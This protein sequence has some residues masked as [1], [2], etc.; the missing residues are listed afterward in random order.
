MCRWTLTCQTKQYVQVN[1][2][3]SQYL[4]CSVGVPQGSIWDPVLF[5]MYIDLPNVC[6][7]VGTIMYVD[8][9][10]IRTNATSPTE[11]AQ[12]LTS[13][14]A[15]IQKWLTNSCLDLNTIKNVGMF[16]SKPTTHLYPSRI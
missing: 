15:K 7:D 14:M 9:A 11:A 13:A 10:V 1:G 2:I 16:L 5:S 6:E 8:D 12:K 4:N 3:K